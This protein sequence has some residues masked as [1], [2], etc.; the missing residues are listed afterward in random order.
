MYCTKYTLG[1]SL[2]FQV[3]TEVLVNQH[4]KIINLFIIYIQLIF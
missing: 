3:Y 2:Y 4:S 1:F